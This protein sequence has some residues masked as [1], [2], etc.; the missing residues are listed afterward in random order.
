MSKAWT[1]KKE[2]QLFAAQLA[3]SVGRDFERAVLPFIRIIWEN[4]ISPTPMGS[5][6]RLGADHLVW[7]DD[8]PFPLVAQ[9]KGFEVP[10]EEL[11]KAQIAQ[12]LKSI[13]SF[14]ES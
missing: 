9:C 1:D 3:T 10:E 2:Y 12:C 4:A 13:E 7:A 11:G 6:D 5:Y 14:Q 8:E